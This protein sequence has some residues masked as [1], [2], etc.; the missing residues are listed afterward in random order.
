MPKYIITM[1]KLK[2]CLDER[3]NVVD[4]CRMSRTLPGSVV[5]KLDEDGTKTAMTRPAPKPTKLL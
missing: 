5:W 3:D 1:P 2:G 4:A